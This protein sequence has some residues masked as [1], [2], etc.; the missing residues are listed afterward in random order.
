MADDEY[1]A[2]F[3]ERDQLR[4]EVARLKSAVAELDGARVEE[5][6]AKLWYLSCVE[7]LEAES[8]SGTVCYR[9]PD[10]IPPSWAERY[11]AKARAALA[12]KGDD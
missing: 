4:E 11:R 2:I 9:W 1:K 3:A 8:P 7:V 12:P 6:A 5:M 10:E